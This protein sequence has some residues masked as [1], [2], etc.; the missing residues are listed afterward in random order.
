MIYSMWSMHDKRTRIYNQPVFYRNDEVAKVS[1]RRNI[2]DA[3][4]KGEISEDVLNDYQFVKLAEFDDESGRI[5]E[6]LFEKL[7]IIECGGISYGDEEA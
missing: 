7:L 3:L 2:Q 6:M 5:E 4:N 1:L